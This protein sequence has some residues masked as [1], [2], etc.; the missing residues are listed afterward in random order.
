MRLFNQSGNTSFSKKAQGEK[1]AVEKQDN[2]IKIYDEYGRE[3]FVTKEEWR[4]N[5]LPGNIKRHWNN[6]DELYQCMVTA[7]YD[8]SFLDILDASKRLL[9]IDTNKE[10]AYTVRSIVLMENKKLKE[11][12]SVLESYIEKYGETGYVLTNLA[13]IYAEAGDNSKV[14]ELLWKGLQLDP[15]QDNGLGWWLTIHNEKGG[16]SAYLDELKKISN[17]KGSWRAQ[18]WL[19]RESLEKKDLSIA[20]QHYNY[21]ISKAKDVPDVLMMISGDLGKA[22]YHDE[23]FNLILPIYEPGK[24][25]VCVGLNILQSYL[26]SKKFE[27]GQQFLKKMFSLNRPDIREKLMFYSNKFEDNIRNLPR[28]IEDTQKISAGIFALDKPIFYYGLKGAKWLLP[29]IKREGPRIG[30]MP[31]ANINISKKGVIQM[32]DAIGRLARSLPLYISENLFFE[33]NSYTQVLVTVATD[34]GLI[35]SGKEYDIDYFLKAVAKSKDKLEFDFFVSGSIKEEDSM[36]DI[37]LTIWDCKDKKK[38]YSIT[39]KAP[40]EIIG[41]AVKKLIYD[42]RIFMKDKKG[43]STVEPIHY[44]RLLED[45]LVDMQLSVYGQA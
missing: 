37:V 9:E 17:I 39:K 43:F 44:Y 31:L 32:E 40:K 3:L 30:F 23:V 26:E 33:T 6:P 4:K 10:R 1:E 14:K 28:K 22:G 15:N 20:K 41:K 2:L 5:V 21:I 8:K 36:F 19:A 7:L 34:G 35:T 29:E 18:L 38:I 27:E 12:K 45:N 24:H 13:K 25:D 16:K 11:A 42:L